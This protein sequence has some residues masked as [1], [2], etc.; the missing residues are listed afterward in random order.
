MY[1]KY[2]DRAMSKV[3]LQKCWTTQTNVLETFENRD[4][5]TTIVLFGFMI[6]S[7][8]VKSTWNCNSAPPYIFKA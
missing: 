1:N 4:A 8:E 6:S 5:L 7:V 2:D 3:L